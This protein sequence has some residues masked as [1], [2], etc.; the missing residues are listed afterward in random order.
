MKKIIFLLT[1]FSFLAMSCKEE[2]DNNNDYEPTPYEVTVP[3]GFPAINLS[4]ENPLTVEGIALGRRLYYDYALDKNKSKACA[5]CHLQQSAFSSPVPNVLPHINL[6]WDRVFLWNGKVEGALEEIML[7]EVEDFLETNISDLNN[8]SEYP[9]LFNKAFGVDTI[10]SREVSFA[11]A[12]FARTLVSGNSRYDRVIRSELFFTDEESN[13]YDIFFSEKGDCFHCHSAPLFNDLSYHNIGLDSTFSGV[14]LGRY[15]M[16]GNE[17]DI[18]KMATP[19][20]RNIELTGPYMHDGR[21]QT[22]EEVVE[23]YNSGVKRSATLDPIMT[24]LG[25]EHG[26][27]LTAQEKSDLIAFLKSLTDTAFTTNPALSNPF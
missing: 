27:N 18:G 19:T 5:S 17:F 15:N 26:L 2:N 10:S 12:Q 14:D 25:K 22:L 23:F 24:K 13:G 21:F 11:L 9:E 3:F 20:L 7:F 1:L 6:G 16:T 8:H 4:Q